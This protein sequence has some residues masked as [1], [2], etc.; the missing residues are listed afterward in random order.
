MQD[1]PGLSAEEM[2]L[3]LD[4]L[5]TYLGTEKYNRLIELLADPD[6]GVPTVAEL[7]QALNGAASDLSGQIA[8]NTGRLE[9]LLDETAANIRQEMNGSIAGFRAEFAGAVD[10]ILRD[11]ADLALDSGG[12][13]MVRMV[14]DPD[15]KL[16]DVYAY[17]D[18]AAKSASETAVMNL[19]G[20]FRWREVWT[21]T[22]SVG[23]SIE[24]PELLDA[25]KTRFALP[26][27]MVCVSSQNP[28]ELRADDDRGA[29][30]SGSSTSV[31]ANAMQTDAARLEIIGGQITLIACRRYSVDMSSS[32]VTAAGNQTVTAIYIPESGKT[33]GS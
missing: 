6:E 8:Q 32:V 26:S 29:A 16:E 3:C 12:G 7:G 1:I 2:Q 20:T 13:D 30:L 27:V 18:R 15:S 4:R 25:G 31:T 33:T 10:E 17:A 14:Y 5:A 24:L 21:G 28:A 11:I 9:T 23:G 19:P 22:L